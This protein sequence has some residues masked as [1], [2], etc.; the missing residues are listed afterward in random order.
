[1][2]NL[3]AAMVE[4]IL[5][6]GGIIE[7]PVGHFARL[8]QMCAD[9]GMLLILDEAQ[10]G[11]GRTGQMYAFERDGVAP[12]ILTL[13]K[14]LGVGLPVAMVVTSAEIEATCYERKYLFYTTHVSDPLAAAVT[15]AVLNVLERDGLVARAALLGKVMADRF[16]AL[17]KEKYEVVGDVRGRGLLRSTPAGP[18]FSP[19]SISTRDPT[20]TVPDCQEPWPLVAA[21]LRR[22]ASGR[23][24]AAPAQ[25]PERWCG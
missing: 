15:L 9:R 21:G 6:S 11:L 12:D 8:K 16:T 24:V 20:Q 19:L 23:A 18:Q 2:G 17:L 14:T 3:A 25:L 13:S 1:M 5:S 22:T 4:P 10:T 7:P